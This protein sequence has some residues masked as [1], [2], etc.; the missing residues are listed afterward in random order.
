MRPFNLD[1]IDM[2]EFRMMDEEKPSEPASCPTS[3][4]FTLLIVTSTIN[5]NCAYMMVSALES[6][7]LHEQANWTSTRR[8][9]RKQAVLAIYDDLV[10]SSPFP[11]VLPATY[12]LR[13]EY[14]RESVESEV[15]ESDG[16]EEST[17]EERSD[18][19]SN[20]ES[21]IPSQRGPT[22]Q[23]L[24]AHLQSLRKT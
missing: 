13:V 18:L 21:R 8:I 4:W 1:V 9:N 6:Q 12:F 24:P 22:P 3:L 16:D 15:G 17:K 5:K 10:K 23:A 14:A 20:I 7:V 2:E 11:N 19:A